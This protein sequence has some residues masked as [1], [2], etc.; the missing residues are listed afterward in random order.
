MGD[1]ELWPDSDEV[2][3]AFPFELDT[4]LGGMKPGLPQMDK[5][6]G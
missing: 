4:T 1:A 2:V 6:Y 5:D 3:E